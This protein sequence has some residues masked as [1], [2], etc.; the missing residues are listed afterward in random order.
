MQ[1]NIKNKA[2]FFLIY[3]LLVSATHKGFSQPDS[4]IKE[5]VINEFSDSESFPIQY[6]T[7][8]YDS[9]SR[10]K[11][12]KAFY[13]IS[14]LDSLLRAQQV[15]RINREPEK[16]EEN[17]VSFWELKLVKVFFWGVAVIAVLFLIY[18][19]FINKGGFVINTKKIHFSPDSK[20]YSE[21]D[22][23]ETLLSKA[24]LDK[25]YRLGI[26]FLF[27]KTLNYLDQKGLI[28]LDK[29]KTNYEYVSELAVK[30][31]TQLF[32]KLCLQY[33]YIWFGEFDINESQ[34]YSISKEFEKFMEQV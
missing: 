27:L 24:I 23:V 7:L 15:A 21:V 33:E 13:Y 14:F 31:N 20:D 22:D 29:Y 8:K 10:I 6:R 2:F 26:R 19:L 12:D 34:F 30:K 5:L 25:N 1:I 32:S 9:I 18:K 11:S 4:S 16:S 17:T 28:H 3:I